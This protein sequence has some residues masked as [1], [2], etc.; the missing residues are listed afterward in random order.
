MG[1][2]TGGTYVVTTDGGEHWKSAVVPGA[3]ND[4]F[5]DVWR[6]ERQGR[7]SHVRPS[8]TTPRILRFTRLL[9]AARIGRFSLRM[10]I[11]L[12]FYDCH[13]VLDPGIEG[14]RTAIRGTGY[15]LTF[16]RPMET[17]GSPS[18]A[19]CRSRFPAK[20]R[21][22]QAEPALPRREKQMRGLPLAA[23]RL[24]GS[25]LP[26]TEAIPGTRYDTPLLS[27]LQ[28][29]REFPWRFATHVTESSAAVT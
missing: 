9:T 24:R 17:H 6:R 5:R 15:F 2:G 27:L 29:G 28:R 25:S 4:Q 26:K 7:L 8:E 1:A 18:P 12:A 16:A 21:L 10:R 23:Q 3:E 22:R 14:S 20:P 13:H 11:P 19:I